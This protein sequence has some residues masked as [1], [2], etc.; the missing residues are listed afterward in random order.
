LDSEIRALRDLPDPAERIRKVSEL[1]ARRQEEITELSRIRRETL[2]DLQRQGRSQTEIA[3]LAGVSRGRI[4]QLA[5]AG[6][7]PERAFLGDGKLTIVVGR[8]ETAKGEPAVAEE[9]MIAVSRLTELAASHRLDVDV[10]RVSPPGLVELNQDNLVILA[11]PRLF[12]MVGQILQGDPNIRFAQEEDGAWVLRDLKTGETYGAPREP[13][14]GRDFGYLGRLPRPDGQGT[15]LVAG[16]LHATGT[17][18]VVAYLETA[19]ADLY[20]EVKTR[21]FSM[22]VECSYNDSLEVTSAKQASPI[23]THTTRS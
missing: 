7:A 14:P 2:G 22:I 18:G 9:T 3:E 10:L 15:F 12:P 19:L 21:R 23:Y 4:A 6:P 8:K 11:G 1:L 17:Q 5:K 16:G 13:G 20:A